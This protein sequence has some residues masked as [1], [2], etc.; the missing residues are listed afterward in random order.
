MCA[1]YLEPGAEDSSGK[2]I[3]NPAFE[4]ALCSEGD[5]KLDSRD[6]RVPRWGG[7]MKGK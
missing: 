6:A 5:P 2:T 4:R 1:C 3:S 7:S